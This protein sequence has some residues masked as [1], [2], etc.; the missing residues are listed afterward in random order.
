MGDS[1]YKG[2]EVRMSLTYWRN[3]KK[4][5]V[6]PVGEVRGREE[7]GEDREMDRSL[8][9]LMFSFFNLKNLIIYFGCTGCS[10]RHVGP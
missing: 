2:P 9:K 1:R 6:A 4:A 7:R 10:P 8:Y 3:S 5:S